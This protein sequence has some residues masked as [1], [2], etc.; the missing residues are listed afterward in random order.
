MKKFIFVILIFLATFAFTQAQTTWGTYQ[1]KNAFCGYINAMTVD[2]TKTSSIPLYTDWFDWTFFA[3][4][5]W[6]ISYSL[7]EANFDHADGFDTVSI[8][9]EGRDKNGTYLT[10]DTVGLTVVS[11]S[12]QLLGSKMY[13]PVK[14]NNAYWFPAVRLRIIPKLTGAT[15]LHNGNGK[16]YLSI[17]GQTS[18]LPDDFKVHGH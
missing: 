6:Y 2:S 14:Y 17:F 4:R 18:Y 8:F 5:A 9:I 16:F 15:T 3:P 12:T 10:I 7:V 13:V 1:Y 11:R